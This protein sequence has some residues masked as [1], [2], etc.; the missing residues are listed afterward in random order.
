MRLEDQ[1]TYEKHRFRKVPQNNFKKKQ[2]C[3]RLNK[4]FKV[5]SSC[6]KPL[7]LQQHVYGISHL[8][9]L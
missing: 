8:T 6:K 7:H 1:K 5:D 2:I 3:I 4:R 9:L